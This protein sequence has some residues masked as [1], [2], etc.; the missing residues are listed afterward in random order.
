[1]ILILALTMRL[2]QTIKEALCANAYTVMKVCFA[3]KV[4]NVPVNMGVPWGRDLGDKSPPQL[5]VS[6]IVPYDAIHL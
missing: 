5:D 2:V 6:E 1:M 4:H 3:V